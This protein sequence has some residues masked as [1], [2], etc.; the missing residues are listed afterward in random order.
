MKLVSIRQV[1]SAPGEYQ[2]WFC[3]PPD[4]QKWAL[5]T[6]GVFSLDSVDFSPDSDEYLP[7]QVKEQGWIETLEVAMIEDVIFNAQAQLG[8]TSIEQL[9]L[10]FVFF[11]Q[12][13]AFI[14]F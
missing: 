9:F 1:L 6:L 5:D 8:T 13:D 3:L 10:A 11:F 4:E 2:N 12:N 7:R 14:E